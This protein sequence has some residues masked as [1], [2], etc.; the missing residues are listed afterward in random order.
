MKSNHAIAWNLVAVME[1]ALYERNEM[2]KKIKKALDA[3]YR[4][5][6]DDAKAHGVN[7]EPPGADYETTLPDHYSGA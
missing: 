5:G 7:W 3:A 6:R 4:R 2:I 1:S